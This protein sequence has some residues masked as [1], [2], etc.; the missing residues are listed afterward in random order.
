MKLLFG[1]FPSDRGSIQLFECRGKSWSLTAVLR[2]TRFEIVSK[3]Y[4]PSAPLHIDRRVPEN[5]CFDLT[6]SFDALNSVV[7]S[8][9]GLEVGG[10]VIT[11]DPWTEPFTDCVIFGGVHRG[12]VE[13][14]FAKFG[15]YPDSAV[16]F[17]SHP[18]PVV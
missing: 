5:V 14:H 17:S 13:C 4:W 10:G 16:H 6:L 3:L 2:R 8:L 11:S 9:E 18:N 15:L 1:P 12:L 7:V